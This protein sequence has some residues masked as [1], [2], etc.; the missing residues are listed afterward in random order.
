MPGFAEGIACIG[1]TEVLK[2]MGFIYG[3]YGAYK[4]R[5]KFFANKAKDPHYEAL[6][7]YFLSQRDTQP[8]YDRHAISSFVYNIIWA[9]NMK[10]I[11]AM[12]RDLGELLKFIPKKHRDA[13]VIIIFTICEH[14]YDSL[15]DR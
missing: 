4:K 8:L 14:L 2:D 11:E 15:A 9:H 1:K 12:K 6:F 10:D 3:D 7:Q 5:Y 13:D